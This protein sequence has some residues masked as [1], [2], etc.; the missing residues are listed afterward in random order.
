MRW[1]YRG[2]PRTGK[3]TRSG[4]VW[5]A[6]AL[7]ISSGWMD[8]HATPD[9][10]TP[11]ERGRADLAL[12]RRVLDGDERA[13]D[14]FVERMDC[15]AR[16]LS[17]RNRRAGRP[18]S[19]DELLDLVQDVQLRIWRKL[20]TYEGRAPLESFALR[21]CHLGLLRHHEQRGRRREQPGLVSDEVAQDA[22]EPFPVADESF[23]TF[24]RPLSP[25]EA[26]VT[27]LRFVE[28]LELDEIA[29]EL[30]VS[31][32]SVKT[33]LYRALDKLRALIPTGG[34]S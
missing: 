5:R 28:S 10:R 4:R 7:A 25:R 6:R 11:A 12:V 13:R 2:I 27:R 20:P 32:S 3:P 9:R 17:A 15:V 1:F 19:T 26:Q 23:A 16:I 31:T 24:L 34:R 33:L 18:A 8:S 22:G 30:S 29:S 14:A 21:F